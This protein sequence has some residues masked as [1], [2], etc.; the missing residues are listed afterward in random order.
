MG[1]TD[2]A[3][4]RRIVVVL[5]ILL[6]WGLVIGTKLVRLQV[7]DHQS[8]R[9]RAERQQQ[10]GLELSPTRGVIYDRNGQEL[11]RSAEVRSLY[12]SPSQV[13]DPKA[14]AHRL[15]SLLDVDA[16]ALFKRL[17]SSQILVAVKRK[18]SDREVRAVEELSLPGLRFVAEMKRFY[19]SGRTASHVLG[20][21]DIDE[22]GLGGVELSYDRIIRGSG[23][24][25]LI[26][27]DALKHPYDHTV[28][29]KVPGANVTLTIDTLIQHDAERALAQV[30]RSTNA[31]GGMV[32]V[33]R[34][35]TGEILALANI[36]TFD[37]NRVSETSD[38]QRSNAA[39]EAAFEPGSIFKIVTYAAALEEGEI[40]PSKRIDC[41]R[42]EITVAGRTIRDG[43]AGWLTAS[44]ALAKSSNVAAI[45]IGQQL[46]QAR[47]ARYIDKFGFGRRTGIELPAE[48]RGILRDVTDWTGAS[49]GA[50]PLGHE[51]GVTALQAA[52]AF[53]CIANGGLWVKPYIVSRVS[54]SDGTIVSEHVPEARR[55]VSRNTT[56]D[57]KT[58]LEG[59]VIN[60]TG[61]L[62]QVSGYRVAGK[63]GT[64]QKIDEAT[65]RYSKSRHVASFAGFAPF[66]NPEVACI[67]SIDEPKGPHTG[68]D[69]A[70]PVFA[71]VV[72]GALQVLGIPPERS[73][74]SRMP[75]SEFRVYDIPR[76]IVAVPRDYGSVD[77]TISVD[78]RVTV[79]ELGGLGLRDALALCTRLGLIVKATGDGVIVQQ[80][81]PPGARAPA[82]TNC[83][84]TLSRQ[85][86]RR[87]T[88]SV[89]AT[90]T[91]N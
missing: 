91:V 11:A 70:A 35:A 38:E 60:G 59:V 26:D 51:V 61:K 52:A 84:L 47:L 29:D 3:N 86:Q 82:G 6:V 48:S 19:M 12:A 37:P 24:R 54:G 63:T 66:D 23:G 89:A 16:D 18:L 36:P 56:E 25:L 14:T 40:T 68:R 31:R 1:F 2:K 13:G 5:A 8:L 22:R 76:T 17:T 90:G 71:Q 73:P 9:E 65:G 83:Y 57:L 32:V 88:A 72:A 74:R 87:A 69:I 85:D 81:P 41:G 28:E 55:V 15:A 20:F 4:D 62:A 49:L 21:V 30:V 46:G 44:R 43:H 39:I 34:P 42:G 7:G 50:I 64:A 80:S 77:S 45:K 33:I 27:V 10:F 79:P 67:V 78:R 53:A 75:E 58:M